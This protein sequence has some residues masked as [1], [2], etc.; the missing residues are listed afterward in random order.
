MI[1]SNLRKSKIKKNVLFSLLTAP[2]ISDSGLVRTYLI[3]IMLDV[4]ISGEERGSS[5]LTL[6][7]KDVSQLNQSW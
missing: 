3:F 1:D 7:V 6:T 5:R 2:T 4:K